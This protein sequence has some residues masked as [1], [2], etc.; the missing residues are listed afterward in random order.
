METRHQTAVILLSDIQDFTKKVREDEEQALIVLNNH[1][2]VVEDQVSAFKGKVIHHREDK[3]LAYFDS[4]V[5]AIKCAL[6]IQKELLAESPEVKIS[7]YRRETY[8]GN[9][10]RHPGV[11]NALTD[12]IVNEPFKGRKT[13]LGDDF[14]KEKRINSRNR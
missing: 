10:F 14:T 5:F 2:T 7:Q 3:S 9:A 1:R 12:T 11:Y 13:G 6:S 4:S 8:F